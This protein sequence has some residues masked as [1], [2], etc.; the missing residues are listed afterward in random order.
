MKEEVIFESPPVKLPV[1]FIKNGVKLGNSYK[2]NVNYNNNIVKMSEI[3][4]KSG[5]CFKY[6]HSKVTLYYSSRIELKWRRALHHC[7]SC[8]FGDISS[9]GDISPCGAIHRGMCTPVTIEQLVL[10]RKLDKPVTHSATRHS[11]TKSGSSHIGLPTGK[12]HSTS[13]VPS[14]HSSTVYLQVMFQ[15]VP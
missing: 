6:V 9:N 1:G 5:A 11:H 4:T 8:E 14:S 10:P 2:N 7:Q 13:L 3:K 15:F 12:H